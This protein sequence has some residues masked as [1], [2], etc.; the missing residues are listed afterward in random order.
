LNNL[1]SFSFSLFLFTHS[2]THW[3]TYLLTYSFIHSL[4]HSDSSFTHSE[5][6]IHISNFSFEPN[7]SF[8][9]IIFLIFLFFLID[10]ENRRIVWILQRVHSK[11]VANWTSYNYCILFFWLNWIFQ[12]SFDDFFT[13]KLKDIYN[14]WTIATIGWYSAHIMTNTIWF[15]GDVYCQ[16]S[17]FCCWWCDSV[18]T[19]V[20][21]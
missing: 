8:F 17:H 1:F 3:L 13:Q 20:R 2:F 14:L 21:M 9:P 12:F 16:V 4:T 18:C 19:C 11:L 5:S 10:F 7:F 15:D 6:L